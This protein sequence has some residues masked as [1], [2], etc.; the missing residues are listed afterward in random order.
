[1]ASP[2][3]PIPAKD[4]TAELADLR[5]AD[6]AGR[7]NLG[8]GKAGE[9]YTVEER[10][11]GTILLTPVAIIP[12]REAW[13]WKNTEALASVRRGIEQSEK[14]ELQSLGSFARHAATPEP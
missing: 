2:H 9:T 3:S 11:D 8:K 5:R 12:K 13:I 10:P 6:G 1:M 7:L 4:S 14:E